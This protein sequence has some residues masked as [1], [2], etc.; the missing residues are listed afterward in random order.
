MVVERCRADRE[1]LACD[2]LDVHYLHFVRDP[3]G[4]LRR[5][6]EHCDWPWSARAERAEMHP[7]PSFLADQKSTRRPAPRPADT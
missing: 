7:C 3:L 5:V 4:T 1:R 2:V 6:H